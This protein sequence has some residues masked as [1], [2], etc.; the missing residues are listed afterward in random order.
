MEEKKKRRKLKKW[1]VALLLFPVVLIFAWIVF[2]T[3][4]TVLFVCVIPPD[5]ATHSAIIESFVRM[6]MY[7]SEHRKFPAS[8]DELPKRDG[9][10]NCITD[11]WERPLIYKVEQDNLITLLSYGKD[12]K[13]GGTG[14]NAD[15]QTTYRTKNPDGEWCIEEQ[16]WLVTAEVKES[17]SHTR[18]TM[19]S[20]E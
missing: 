20:D 5:A 4:F 9:Y 3:T 6:Q 1:I 13:P 7:I 12:G 2:N 18:E 11:G 8:L 14:R 16:L 19:D 10:A 17:Q 15:I